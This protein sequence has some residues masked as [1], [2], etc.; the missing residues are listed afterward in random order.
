M[1]EIWKAHVLS[2]G[3]SAAK[4]VLCFALKNFM[5]IFNRRN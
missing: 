3:L 5:C 4:A 2:H 1:R